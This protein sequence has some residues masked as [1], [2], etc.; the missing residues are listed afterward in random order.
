V[1]LRAAIATP[2]KMS[3]SVETFVA[4]VSACESLNKCFACSLRQLWQRLSS[5]NVVALNEAKKDSS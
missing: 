2:S 5:A 3:N 4:L 1:P